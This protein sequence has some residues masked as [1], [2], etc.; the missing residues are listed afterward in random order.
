MN[1][2]WRGCLG[3][4]VAGVVAVILSGNHWDAAAFAAVWIIARYTSDWERSAGL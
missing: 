3:A 4:C 1:K 2:Y